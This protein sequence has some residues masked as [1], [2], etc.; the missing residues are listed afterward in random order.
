MRSSASSSLAAPPEL[1]DIRGLT[2]GD[3]AVVKRQ[4]RYRE[5]CTAADI[6]GLLQA[7]AEAKPGLGR[8]DSDSR[9]TK[10]RVAAAAGLRA[11]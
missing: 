11:A 3:F 2:P 10:H 1:A 9:R 7:E 5:T 6:I 4:L 8:Q